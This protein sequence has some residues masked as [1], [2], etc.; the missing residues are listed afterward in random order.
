MN[1][2]S[3]IAVY[4]ID[5]L[6]SLYLVAVVLRLILQTSGADFFNP[7]SQ[8]I[9]KVTNPPLLLLRKV[10]PSAGP[11]EFASVFLALAIQLL[12]ITLVLFFS[13]YMPPGIHILLWW[14]V[15]GVVGLTVN[16]YFFALI[17]MIVISW[18]APTSSHPAIRLLY[19]I[20]EPVMRPFRS[21]LPNMGGLDFSPILVFIL[22][23]VI[24]IALRHAAMASGL[25][26]RLVVGL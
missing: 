14:S 18:V 4:L 10:I 6:T 8:F 20:T 16:I 13:G 1:A 19:Q 24:Q 21:M 17:A 3:E 5:T 22:I 26:T 23:Q 2:G 9:A 12:A 7:I 25:P 11:I 15:L